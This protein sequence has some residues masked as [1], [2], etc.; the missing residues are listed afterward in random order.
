MNSPP[1]SSAGPAAWAR[2]TP[3]VRGIL[4]M[5]AAGLLFAALNA[6]QKVLTHDMYPPQVVCLRYLTGSIILL[7][8]AIHAGWAAYRPRRPGF[9]AVRSVFHAAGSMLWFIALPF[10][11]LAET[12][13]IGFTG[14]IYMMLGASLFLGERMYAARW[15]AV[16]I[17]FAGVLV[18]L[19]PGLVDSNIAS[20]ATV[21]MLVS[22]PLFAASFLLSKSL[23]RYDRPEAIVFWLGVMIAIFSLPFAIFAIEWPLRVAFTWPTLLQWVLLGA[24]GLVGS[25]AHYC[26]TRAYRIA[27]V[28]A[29]QSVR[30]L[31]MVWAS[32]FGFLMFTHLP[33]VWA[34]AG[35]TIICAATLWIARHEARHPQEAK[36]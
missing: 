20:M 7:P 28:S 17:A 35:G 4:W 15:G 33:T 24:C 36:A 32:L 16:L 14:P 12:S 19:W 18:V 21:W 9:M 13:A 25:T 1:G 23:T 10:V 34:L 31:D 27:D 29:V 30:F 5:L 26:M 22:S 2:L 11:G 6:Q 8:F 3:S